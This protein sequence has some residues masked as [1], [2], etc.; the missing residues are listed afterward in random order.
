M[1]NLKLTLNFPCFYFKCG[2]CLHACAGELVHTHSPG[3]E[4]SIVDKASSE[5]HIQGTTAQT[6]PVP[7]MNSTLFSIHFFMCYYYV[8]HLH[9][10]PNSITLN[11][12]NAI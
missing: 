5:W 7:S 10:S 6:L 8:V 9:F 11:V 1:Q 2:L 4:T 12:Y 3:Y